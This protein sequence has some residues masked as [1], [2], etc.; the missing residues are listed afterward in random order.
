MQCF[1]SGQIV[2]YFLQGELSPFSDLSRQQIDPEKLTEYV[3]WKALP[4][5]CMTCITLTDRKVRS[6]ANETS[7]YGIEMNLGTT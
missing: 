3:K 1:S 2:A 5:G 6:S 4:C 7:V